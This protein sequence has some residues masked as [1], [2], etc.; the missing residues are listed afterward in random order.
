MYFPS[1]RTNSSKNKLR[2]L[3]VGRKNRPDSIFPS[4]GRI[5]FTLITKISNI[6]EFLNIKNV[7]FLWILA[8]LGKKFFRVVDFWKYF[9]L[10]IRQPNPDDRLEKKFRKMDTL[11]KK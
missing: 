8:R 4:D 2:Y 3:S 1:R 7:T 11:V 5:D 6:T 10:P 9:F